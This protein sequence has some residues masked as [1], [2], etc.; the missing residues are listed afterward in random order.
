M[1]VIPP[2][3]LIAGARGGF[4]VELSL[5]TFHGKT[6]LPRWPK[7]VNEDEQHTTAEKNVMVD[8]AKTIMKQTWSTYPIKHWLKRQGWQNLPSHE[9]AL[10]TAVGMP[11]PSA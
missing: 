9:W 8:H 6:G 3:K 7:I 5:V 1:M 11:G 2:L 10:L 4:T